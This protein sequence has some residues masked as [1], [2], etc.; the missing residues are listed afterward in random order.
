MKKILILA[1]IVL[2]SVSSAYADC[3]SDLGLVFTP[4]Q[5]VALCSVLDPIETSEI[6]S[7]SSIT[8]EVDSDAQRV[9]TFDASSDTALTQTFGDGGTTAAQTFALSASTADADDDSTVVIAGGGALGTAGDRGSSIKL[10][11]NETTTDTGRIDISSGNVSGTDVYLRTADDVHVTNLAGTLMITMDGTTGT[12]ISQ[13]TGS[14]GWTIQ[15]A[16]NQ[17]CNTTCVS[18]CVAGID[19]A[20]GPFLACTDAT[21]DSCLCAGGA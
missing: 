13:G 15:S 16:A 11:G 5:R 2:G 1:A 6:T 7:S 10:T 9:F 17:A 18:A 21:A 14:I 19:T 20:G 4:A 8:L 12:L 3:E